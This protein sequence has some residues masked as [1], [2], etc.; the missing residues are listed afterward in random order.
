VNSLIDQHFHTGRAL[1]NCLT[2]WTADFSVCV[3]YV[4]ACCPCICVCVCCCLL[5]E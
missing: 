4:V 1:I 3:I 5:D 2:S